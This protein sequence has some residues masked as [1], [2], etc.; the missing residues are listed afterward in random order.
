MTDGSARMAASAFVLPTAP[1]NGKRVNLRYIDWIWHIRGRLPLPEGVTGEEAFER[2]DPLFGETGTSHERA[3]DTLTFRKRDAAAQDKMAVFDSGTLTIE[4][5]AQGPMLRWHMISRALLACFLAPLLFL[6]FA[7][8]SIWLNT[9]EKPTPA[10]VAEKKKKEEEAEKK[11]GERQLHA[12]DKFLGA[13]APEKP[14]TA[15][16]KKKEE[17]EKAKKGEKEED[18]GNH[19]PTPAYVFA[20]LF[21]FLWLAGRLL[22]D[23]LIRRQFRKKL[24]GV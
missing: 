10:E 19:S 8:F 3:G 12:I 5:G 6:A 13:P 20:G 23:W 14:K 9:I 22:E 1:A 7:Q 4:Q 18:E 15:A 17:A 16:E 11:K 21:A 2:L 24:Q